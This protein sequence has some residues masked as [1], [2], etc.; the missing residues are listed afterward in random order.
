[1]TTFAKVA[2]VGGGFSGCSGRLVGVASCMLFGGGPRLDK[3]LYSI[4]VGF[5]QVG[6]FGMWGER[7]LQVK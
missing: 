2:Q 1:M 5:L 6:D 4:V 7:C 3:C